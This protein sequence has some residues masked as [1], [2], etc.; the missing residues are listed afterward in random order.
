MALQFREAFT[1]FPGARVNVALGGVSVVMDVPGAALTLGANGIKAAPAESTPSSS[2]QTGADDI[3]GGYGER[4]RMWENPSPPLRPGVGGYVG[5]GSTRSIASAGIDKLTTRDFAT[6]RDMMVAVLDQ[7]GRVAT[8]EQECNDA[9]TALTAERDRKAVWLWKWCFKARL[10]Q[11]EAELLQEL[12]RFDELNAWRESTTSVV[13]FEQS[14]EASLL[15][16]QARAAFGELTRCE[17]CWDLVTEAGIDRFRERSN[18]VRA[19]DRRVVSLSERTT[20]WMSSGVKS[21]FFE[22]ANGPGLAFYPGLMI[23]FD[24]DRFALVSLAELDVAFKAMPFQEGEAVPRDSERIGTTWAK[25]NKDGTPDR[26]FK[27]NYQIPVMRYGSLRLST[28]SGVCEEFMF[29]NCDKAMKFAGAV[30]LLRAAARGDRNLPALAEEARVAFQSGGGPRLEQ[31]VD[32]I[33][34]R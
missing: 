30:G 14:S 2:R 32:R 16:E 1:L 19:V 26:R 12:E 6:L 23:A 4:P 33:L 25:V 17:R 24:G 10:T 20:P 22:N 9:I 3:L 21:L 5:A 18:A 27:D 29:S 13:R 7:R 31:M 28:S 34:R 15:W 8:A 11:I